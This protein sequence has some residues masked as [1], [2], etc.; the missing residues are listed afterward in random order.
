MPCGCNIFLWF[1]IASTNVRKAY[2]RFFENL[3]FFEDLQSY[4]KKTEIIIVVIAIGIKNMIK[5]NE[6][7]FLKFINSDE[8]F[9]FKIFEICLHELFQIIHQS[10]IFFSIKIECCCELNFNF[11]NYDVVFEL[12]LVICHRIFHM[13]RIRRNIYFNLFFFF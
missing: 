10:R 1:Y 2:A 4:L 12:S 13:T 9:E 8:I 5:H 11:T 3:V 6:Q 7:V